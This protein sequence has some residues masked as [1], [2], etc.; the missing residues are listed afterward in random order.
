[1]MQRTEC[2]SVIPMSQPDRH[3]RR[4]KR[5]KRRRRWW[6]KL[7]CKDIL[8]YGPLALFL[9]VAGVGPFVFEFWY[10]RNLLYGIIFLAV[11]AIYVFILWPRKKYR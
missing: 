6:Y 10:H 9:L 11:I 4:K 2:P 1:M 3:R 7:T 5:H 8:L